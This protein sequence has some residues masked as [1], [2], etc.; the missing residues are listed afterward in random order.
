MQKVLY[1]YGGPD[2]HPTEAGGKML[3]DM[4][5]AEGRFS[6]E[7]TDNLDAFTTLPG[8]DYAAVVVYTTGFHDELTPAREQ[9][10]LQFVRNGGGFVGIHSATDSFYGSQA[11]LDMIGGKFLHHPHHH[12]FNV[13]I[14]EKE[15]F[16][17]ARMP[18]FSV[19]DEMYHLQQFDP[20]T[21]TVLA[22]TTWQGKTMPM[23]YS[24]AYGQGRVSYLAN[25]HTL[26]A[27]QHPEFRKLLLRALAWS[28]GANAQER[29]IRCGLLGYGPA[30]NM[31]KGH[32][33]WIDAT[34]GMKTVAMCDA[35][36]ARVEAAKQESRIWKGIS[37]MWMSCWPCRSS[38][39]W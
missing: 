2:F 19:F 33:D 27:W 13:E 36:P 23:A 24:K 14:V 25:G 9:G 29:V 22:K 34:P 38:T 31:G 30:F 21:V 18:N 12:E 37:P 6:L 4:L 35:M 26:Q 3:A 32:G 7:M 17:T 8:S 16:I 5:A 11:Y 1:V 15:H 10:L 39:W 28:A 20:A